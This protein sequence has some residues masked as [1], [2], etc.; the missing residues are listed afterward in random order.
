MT[1][2]RGSASGGNKQRGESEDNRVPVLT[3]P[4]STSTIK[5][6]SAIDGK[7]ASKCSHDDSDK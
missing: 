3:K 1:R 2:D 7:K 6:N 4:K 5:G